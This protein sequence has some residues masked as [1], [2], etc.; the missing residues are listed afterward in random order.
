VCLLRQDGR[1]KWITALPQFEDPVEKDDRIYWSGPVLVSDRLLVTGSSGLAV[2]LSPY[3]GSVIGKQMLPDSSHLPP[4][5]A[6]ETVYILSDD[7]RL[8]ALK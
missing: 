2:S 7:A 1:I 6:N 3:D 8:S 5:V 4:V